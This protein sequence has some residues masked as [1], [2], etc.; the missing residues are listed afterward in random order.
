LVIAAFIW[1]VAI[2]AYRHL[3]AA[4]PRAGGEYRLVG[5]VR[6]L[7][8]RPAAGRRRMANSGAPHS[9]Q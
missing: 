5:P 3:L 7:P 9:G 6:Q 1:F 8:A 2:L 4:I